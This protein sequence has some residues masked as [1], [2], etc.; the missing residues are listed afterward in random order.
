MATLQELG[1]IAAEKRAYDASADA[2]IDRLIRQAVSE[3]HR[4][5]AIGAAMGLCGAAPRLRMKRRSGARTPSSAARG[6]G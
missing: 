5:E 3:G 2:E 6:G 4:W 1:R